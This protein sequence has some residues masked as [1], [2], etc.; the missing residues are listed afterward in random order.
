MVPF[1]NE[2]GT[3]CACVGVSSTAAASGIT[4]DG[5]NHDL[6]F[7]VPK[8]QEL[9][10]QCRFPWLLANVLDPALGPSVPLGNAKPSIVLDDG[11]FKIGVLGLVE[12]EW[13]DTI[14][15]LPPNLIY[16]SASATAQDVALGLRT[17][18][19]TMVIA[20]THQREPNDRK[21]AG[22]LRPGTVDLILGGHDHF[23]GHS[24]VNGVHILRSGTDFKQLSYIQAWAREEL[25]E[26][27]SPKWDFTVTRR[28]VL[29]SL[30][31]D[32]QAAALAVQVSSK[33]RSKLEK[34]I[35]YTAAPLDARFTTVRLRESNYG[36]F[37][38]DIMRLYY[39]ADC[40]IMAAGT[41]R[42]DQIYPPGVLRIKDIMDCFPFED[43]VVVLRVTGAAVRA[44]L[45]N[46]VST[47]PALEGRFPQVSNIK[48]VFDAKDPPMQ[49]IREL[50]ISGEALDENRQ[51]VLATRDYMARGKDG[52]DSL[53]YEENGGTAQT[54]VSEE[55]GLLISALLRQY[56][57]SMRVV[58]TFQR[59]VLSRH[60]SRPSTAATTIDPMDDHWANVQDTLHDSHPVKQPTVSSPPAKRRKANAGE[61]A[62]PSS[63][64]SEDERPLDFAEQEANERRLH[65]ARKATKHWRRMVGLHRH[66]DCV[67]EEEDE[68]GV[69]WTKGVAPRIEGRI[70][71]LHEVTRPT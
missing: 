52:F 31:E 46:A 67:H 21:L 34:Q 63:D 33:L 18:G 64:I 70:V 4:N 54:V 50:T 59:A 36:N 11:P 30:P 38:C 53:L 37:V 16:K 32:P 26:V 58:D 51:Y 49:R 23:Y 7:G 61:A 15:T 14:N 2:I 65:L 47:Y 62:D 41:I 29:R 9:A 24:I 27:D 5:Q 1:L 25:S 40:T 68:I 12:R 57:T 10:S 35:G 6:D 39:G 20:V 45:E 42:G 17:E 28:D 71:I 48:L 56:F 55:N 60:T 13:L 3:T 8:F 43:P 22:K 44:A 69:D 19:C 66:P